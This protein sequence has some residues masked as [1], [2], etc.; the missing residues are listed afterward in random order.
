MGATEE[1]MGTSRG[2]AGGEY[3]D[4]VEETETSDRD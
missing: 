2:V 4:V 3:E 1:D